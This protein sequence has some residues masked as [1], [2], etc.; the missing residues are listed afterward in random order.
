[1]THKTTIEKRIQPDAAY[2]LVRCTAKG[3]LWELA[4]S[5]LPKA[6]RLRDK[7]ETTGR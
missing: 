3:C 1:M 6:Q 5:S 2:W 7:H 4:I